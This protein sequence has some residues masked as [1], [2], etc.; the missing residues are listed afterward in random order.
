MLIRIQL[1][2]A[3]IV[4]I[5]SQ[6]GRADVTITQNVVYAHQPG[7]AL[8]CDVFI[9]ADDANGSAVLFTVSGG[10]SSNWTPPEQFQ[11]FVKP[12]AEFQGAG[13][14]FQGEDAKKV[15][16]DLV[17]WFHEHLAATPKT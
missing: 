12:L 2:L 4:A 17:A 15:T 9:P 3:F 13:H 6:T 8:T 11:H 14:G 16:E 7:L 10:W 1:L 5:A